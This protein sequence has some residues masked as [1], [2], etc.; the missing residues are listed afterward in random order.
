MGKAS[1]EEF[2]L[3][4]TSRMQWFL[5]VVLI[6][7]LFTIMLVL[8]IATLSGVNV[9]NKAKALTSS[10]PFSSKTTVSNTSAT[11]GSNNSKILDLQDQLKNKNAEITKL[12]D[13]IDSQANDKQELEF[14]QKQ[15]QS[16]INDMKKAAQIH[17]KK[18]SDIVSTYTNMSPNSAAAIISNLD[19]NNAVEILA[20]L[21]TDTLAS[22]MEK[23]SPQKAAKYTQM[24]SA[25]TK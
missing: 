18:F 6:P 24:L 7:V 9:I 4:K 13:Q 14:Q 10:L 21:D 15:L 23:L 19:D 8:I 11:I 20:N 17:Q 1:E 3:E 2:E 25:K 16:D 22:I 5:Y 12:Q